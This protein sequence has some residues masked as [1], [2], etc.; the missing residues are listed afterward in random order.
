ME[1]AM[2]IKPLL[3]ACSLALATTL[4]AG[5]YAATDAGPKPASHETASKPAAG[6][7]GKK[8]AA[9]HLAKRKTY[10]HK[11]WVHHKR[12]HHKWAHRKVSHHHPKKVSPAKKKVG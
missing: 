9:H 11:K 6:V 10:R 12:S 2:K 4:G 1:H 7:K 5:A 3:I 8:M